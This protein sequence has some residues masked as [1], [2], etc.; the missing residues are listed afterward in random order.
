MTDRLE[1]SF[2]LA[3]AQSQII[4]DRQLQTTKMMEG[5]D[6]EDFYTN[7]NNKWSALLRAGGKKTE[8]EVCYIFLQGLPPSFNSMVAIESTMIDRLDICTLESLYTSAKNHQ[9]LTIDKDNREES[10]LALLSYKR[11]GGGSSS[12]SARGRGGR[13]FVRGRGGSSSGPPREEKRSCYNCDEIGHLSKE[14]TKPRRPRR[15]GNPSQS[16]SAHVTTQE[17][18]EAETGEISA[19][20]THPDNEPKDADIGSMMNHMT[21]TSALPDWDS[22]SGMMAITGELEASAGVTR[23]L[24]MMTWRKDTLILDSGATSHI[25]GDRTMFRNYVNHTFNITLGDGA[26]M[27]GEGYGDV[28]IVVRS[29]HGFTTITLKNTLHAPR[30]AVNL[31]SVAQLQDSGFA[32][33]AP[34]MT[35][36]IELSYNGRTVMT[37][38]R[39]KGLYAVDLDKIIRPE[40]KVMISKTR[41][42]AADARVWHRR[43]G[44]TNP[45]Y[46]AST[47]KIVSNMEIG[48]G[49]TIS[50]CSDCEACI[51]GKMTRAPWNGAMMR[52]KDI[53][54]IIHIDI[55][56]PMEVTSATGSF[57]YFLLF[58]DDYSRWTVF[59]PLVQRSDAAKRL[60][61]FIAVVEN[62]KGRKIKTIHGDNAS[63]FIAGEFK[64]TMDAH[65][66]EITT[67]PPY[68]PNHN[69]VVE[70]MNM[71]VVQGAK[72]MM[73]DA[74]L[75]KSWWADACR[76]FVYVKNR[77]VCAGIPKDKTPFHLW[78]GS[79]PDMSEI[80]IFGCP[81]YYYNSDNKKQKWD[82]TG[83]K[84]RF[85][86]YCES[87]PAYLIWDGKRNIKVRR[88]D[89]IFFEEENVKGYQIKAGSPINQSDDNE[90]NLPSSS[91][92][93]TIGS[94]SSTSTGSIYSRFSDVER[95]SQR[96]KRIPPH[97]KDYEMK[98]Y[99][100]E[101]TQDGKATDDID[102]LLS[103]AFQEKPNECEKLLIT[104][105]VSTE[106][107][108][109]DEA[110]NGP[111]RDMFIAAIKRE[112][113]A[114]DENNVYEEVDRPKQANVVRCR[115]VLTRKVDG[116]G[117]VVYKARLVAAGYKQRYGVD[118]KETF[119]P[120]VKLHI[121][122]FALSYAAIHDWEIEQMDVVTAF[123]NGNVEEEIYMELPPGI[124]GKKDNS[125]VWR[126]I[127]S[128][129]GLHQSSRMWYQRL[130]NDLI[131]YGFTLIKSDGA[132]FIRTDKETTVILVV[133]VDDILILSNDKFAIKKCKSHLMS[134]YKMKAFGEPRVFL[135]LEIKRDRGNRTIE[136]SQS[137][138]ATSVVEKFNMENS[139]PIGTP[140]VEYS[141]TGEPWSVTDYMSAV[142]SIMY[143][144]LGSR[145]DLCFGITTLARH[146]AN[147]LE[148]DWHAVKRMLR[149]INN[150][151]EMG[152]KYGRKKDWQPLGYCDASF[153]PAGMNFKSIS[154]YVFLTGG[155]AVTWR[156][157]K[158]EVVALSSA[159]AEYVALSSATRE[160]LF[161]RS[162]MHE[163]FPNTNRTIVIMEDNTSTIAISKDPVHQDRTKH[164]AIRYHHIRDEVKEGS[165]KIEFVKSED[166]IADALTKPL[167]KDVFDK[168]KKEMGMTGQTARCGME[169]R[170]MGSSGPEKIEKKKESLV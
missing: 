11:R 59:A 125:R 40:E 106:K 19:F 47:S 14:C 48:P 72:A 17:E 27:R 60:K 4:L 107:V 144:M 82:D 119:S 105:A 93:E 145:P 100:A 95:R 142:G 163:I 21:I 110:L 63:E 28:D 26:K 10:E 43:L 136:I 49:D 20:V 113:A 118:F 35:N 23:E 170:K 13:G 92:G 131:S 154:S 166:N 69:A 22:L 152:I 169:E 52:A 135:G 15:Q 148:M 50:I 137:M 114:M 109:W 77:T 98:T 146:S 61:D 88:S 45:E 12:G 32:V 74:G 71:S 150:T 91:S 84:G 167:A 86:G 46:V 31:L 41:T 112:R 165:I 126:L 133:F 157:K 37:A 33:L 168:H 30:V 99:L 76:A 57:R 38:Q 116:D 65:G 80:K 90:N 96:E 73:A 67:S 132:V 9:M 75:A 42:D 141:R 3:G 51:R 8:R 103:K 36:R 24:A 138:Y 111:E 58:I 54:E 94:T 66:I 5:G 89:C 53:L 44:H 87:E 18:D 29:G 7:L 151:R 34:P 128:L 16:Q 122:R 2:V 70:R 55:C 164:I 83:L 147:P 25:M 85:M 140:Y 161:W 162:F 143:L 156:S 81:V 153:A 123:L 129:Y 120:V 121:V 124:D 64:S 155:G 130:C 6:L 97:L 158:Q 78:M 117:N 102:Q 160:A 56:G 149:Y 159:E 68:T 115:Y 104:A 62:K 101:M 108:E 1:K 134:K 127:K 39:T 79:Q 139:R